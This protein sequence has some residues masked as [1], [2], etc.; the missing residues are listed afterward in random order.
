MEVKPYNI[1]VS[2]SYPPDT[3]TPGYQEEMET[4]PFLTKKLSESGSVFKP[5]QV[6][7]DI[8][9]YSAKGYF[10]ISNGLDGWLLKQ[11]HP[12]MS[13]INNL[14]EFTQGVLMASLARF[15]AMF[16]ILSWDIECRSEVQRQL[17]EGNTA[18]AKKK[19]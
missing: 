16:Y 11:L 15:I 3:D 19:K 10:G 9:T 14:W 4:K 12:G 17:K 5:S 13:P 2:V 18:T 6:A 8:V 1:F 7:S